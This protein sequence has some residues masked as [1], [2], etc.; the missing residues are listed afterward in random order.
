MTPKISIITVCYNSAA[1]IEEAIQSVLNQSYEHK[2]YIV[3]DGGSKDTTLDIIEKY[4]DRI[5][6]FVSEPD[7]GI[8]DAF[9]K[10]IKAATGDIIGI[11]NSDDILASKT[12]QNIA[13]NYEDGVEIYRMDEIIKN[14]DTGEE[15]YLKPTLEFPKIPVNAQPCHMG[16]FVTKDAYNKYGLYDLSMKYCMDAEFLRR[17]TYNGAKYKYIPEV[18]GYFRKGGASS[19]NENKMRNERRVLVKRYGGSRV[20]AELMV[21]FFIVKKWLKRLID[22]FGENTATKLRTRNNA[23]K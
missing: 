9:N 3:I 8:S 4:R 6:Y 10:G 14:F 12:L 7:K 18:C 1:H 2:E 22:I 15:F 13:D 16:C 17:L 20:D 11:C 23:N 19:S 5:D 21:V